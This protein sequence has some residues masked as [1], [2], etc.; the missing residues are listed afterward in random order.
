MPPDG[1]SSRAGLSDAYERRLRIV[2]TQGHMP[3]NPAIEAGLAG[4]NR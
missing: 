1:L 3:Q 4:L 2:L